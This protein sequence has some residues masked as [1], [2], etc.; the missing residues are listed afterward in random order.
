MTCKSLGSSNA[1]NVVHATVAA[2]K[3]LEE[4]EQ[5]A[6]RRGKSVEDVTPAALLRARAEGSH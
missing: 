6:R 3:S 4:P 1:I 2:L 5:V